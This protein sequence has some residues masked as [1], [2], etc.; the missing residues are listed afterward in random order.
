MYALHAAERAHRHARPR[1][2]IATA[3]VFGIPSIIAVIMNYVKPRATRAARGSTATSAG[4]CARSGAR[5][6]GSWSIVRVLARRWF[7]VLG[8][9]FVTM[10]RSASPSSASGSSTA[11]SRG[12]LAL[13][14]G[15]NPSEPRVRIRPSLTV[16][17]PGVASWSS[18]RTKS[19]SF[20]TPSPTTRARCSTA[21]RAAI[22]SPTSTARAT[23]SRASRTRL[24]GKSGGRQARA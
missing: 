20:T 19:S 14:D 12:W 10:W 9:G 8:L 11:S 22:R 24:E 3:F 6:C 17:Q 7:C 18:Q 13:K 21:R 15:R 4:S 2:F 1:P 5:R 16:S 23:S